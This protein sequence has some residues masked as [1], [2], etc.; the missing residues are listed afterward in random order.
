MSGMPRYLI[1]RS[2]D[3]ITE[4]EMQEIAFRFKE[5]GGEHFPD[6]TWEHSHVCADDQGRITSFCIYT[7]PGEERLREHAALMGRHVITNLYEIF[8][9]V[10]P[11]NLV[12]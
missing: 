3:V 6:V 7:A 12:R 2:F 4:D 10:I 8:G 9:D 11:A 5:V 1:E